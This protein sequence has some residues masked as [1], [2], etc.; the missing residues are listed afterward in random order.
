M[1]TTTSRFNVLYGTINT[2]GTC[3][4]EIDLQEYSAHGLMFLTAPT[5]GTL[6]F[7]V[8]EKSH[9]DGGTYGTLREK[10]TNPAY[11]GAPASV[12]SISADD[13][14]FLKPYRYVRIISD[15]AQSSGL[16]IAIPV[17]T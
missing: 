11:V 2:A 16:R 17:R 14:T 5:E 4:E 8:A 12:G 1:A 10:T 6:N 13:L 9:L 3:T 15:V 7:L